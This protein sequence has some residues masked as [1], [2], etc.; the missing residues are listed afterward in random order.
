MVFISAT[1]T[2][3][4]L[5]SSQ[6]QLIAPCVPPRP[7]CST[8]PP[9]FHLDGS[10]KYA[11]GLNAVDK[12]A[13]SHVKNRTTLHKI[14]RSR[15]TQCVPPGFGDAHV[16]VLARQAGTALLELK[17]LSD[18]ML[19]GPLLV[20]REEHCL[21]AVSPA[22]RRARRGEAATVAGCLSFKSSYG[23]GDPPQAARKLATVSYHFT[24]SYRCI[25][26]LYH[27][28]VSYH[29]IISL[30]HITMHQIII[31][32]V[33]SWRHIEDIYHRGREAL[34]PPPAF[35]H[36]GASPRRAVD[37]HAAHAADLK[38]IVP[39]LRRVLSVSIEQ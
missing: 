25:I 10:T 13:C 16:E 19:F 35:S 15:T 2:M 32:A 8:S 5:R 26:S 27:I 18:A 30:Y 17:L 38:R 22:D 31:A 36:P 14:V 34:L 23:S 21:V 28:A 24:V 11:Q 39:L 12:G 4:T 29:C 9:V 7:L 37:E 1:E 6:T 3:G 33:H 20:Q